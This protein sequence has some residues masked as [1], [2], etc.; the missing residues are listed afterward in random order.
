MIKIKICGLTRY[1]DIEYV[2]KL[3]PEYA[4]FVFAESR[5]RVSAG[6]A[7]KLHENLDKEIKAVGV[8]A[9]ES[10]EAVREIADK[11]KLDVLQ[12][13]GN[14]SIEY[15]NSFKDFE[16]W[17]AISVKREE[18]LSNIYKYKNIRL[19]L[20]SKVEGVKGGSGKTFDWNIL[21]KHDLE[22]KIVLAGG[23]NCENIKEAIKIVKPFAVDVSSGVE[24]SGF[25]DFHKMKEFI[26]KVRRL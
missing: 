25:K 26:D 24:S 23:L 14:E 19:L 20:D 13:H 22:Q 18:D 3:R 4:G 1:V 6:T 9:D 21:K 10:I 5:R 17:K 15:I 2:N 12:F 11:V 7:L 16:V 8:F